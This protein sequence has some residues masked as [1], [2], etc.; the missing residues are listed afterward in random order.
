LAAGGDADIQRW[1]WSGTRW[2]QWQHDNWSLRTSHCLL[3]HR[4]I[5][6]RQTGLTSWRPNQY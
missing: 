6:L 3:P 1:G 5:R 2:V 4:A